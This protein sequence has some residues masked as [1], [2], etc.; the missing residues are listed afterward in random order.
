M[1]NAQWSL[2]RCYNRRATCSAPRTRQPLSSSPPCC[3]PGTPPLNNRNL[4]LL[5]AIRHRVPPRKLRNQKVSYGIL[6][7]STRSSAPLPMRLLAI[8]IRSWHRQGPAPPRL[9]ENLQ[10]TVQQFVR[11]NDQHEPLARLDLFTELKNTACNSNSTQAHSPAGLDRVVLFA[12]GPVTQ[13]DLLKENSRRA[14]VIR[15]RHRRRRRYRWVSDNA[16]IIAAVA[17]IFVLAWFIAAR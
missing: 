9:V 13:A 15:H 10:K 7:R 4:K 1:G 11:A 12:P 2:F 6:P 5:Q 8:S 17:V 3:S 16:G 14:V